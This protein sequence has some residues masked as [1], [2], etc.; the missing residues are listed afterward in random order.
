MYES[1]KFYDS[2]GKMVYME[3]VST[4]WSD[5]PGGTVS[6]H[7]ANFVCGYQPPKTQKKN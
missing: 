4:N 7:I 5:I 6:E 1:S 2:L 3:N